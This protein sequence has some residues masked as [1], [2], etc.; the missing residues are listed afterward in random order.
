MAAAPLV[1]ARERPSAKTPSGAKVRTQ[2]ITTIMAPARPSKNSASWR[3]GSSARRVAAVAN[4]AVKTITGSMASSAAAVKTLVGRSELR[5]SAKPG[6]S[7]S[8]VVLAGGRLSAGAGN[9][10]SSPGISTPPRTALA[11]RTPTIRISVRRAMAPASAAAAVSMMPVNI[12]PIT[13]G[14][15][16]ILSACSQKPPSGRAISSRGGR[17][18]VP[19]STAPRISPAIRPASVRRPGT[20]ISGIRAA[21]LFSVMRFL[22]QVRPCDITKPSRHSN[23]SG[24]PW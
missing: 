10:A 19:C 2:P 9:K 24:F 23:L 20:R 1:A 16:V 15:I 13:S 21:G 14:R 11:A 3:R 22:W 5:K 7:A 17:T 6:R 4:S 12:R 8:G 18:L